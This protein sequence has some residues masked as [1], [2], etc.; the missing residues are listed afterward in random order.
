MTM[1]IQADAGEIPASC[2]LPT[3]EQPL[4]VAEFDRLFAESLRRFTRV[5]AT[6]LDLVLASEAETAARELAERET[7]CCSFFDFQFASTGPEVVM[8]IAVPESHTDVLDA[9][10]DRIHRLSS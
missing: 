3:S 1:R 5:N 10:T 9:M 8:S 2:S 6:A 7:R 4:R